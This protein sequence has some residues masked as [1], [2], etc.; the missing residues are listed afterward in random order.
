MFY[1]LHCSSFCDKN[2]N[3]AHNHRFSLQ[4][5]RKA[6]DETFEQRFLKEFKITCENSGES[7]MKEEKRSEIRHGSVMLW[8]LQLTWRMVTGIA[9]EF[10]I[11]WKLSFFMSI[12]QR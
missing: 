4:R 5:K 3:L 1:S 9:F 8:A 6:A 2:G 7:E 10:S 11:F 12:S